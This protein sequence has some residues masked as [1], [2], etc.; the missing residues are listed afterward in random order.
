MVCLGMGLVLGLSMPCTVQAGKE[1][2]AKDL[3]I[4][5]WLSKGALFPSAKGR[6]AAGEIRGAHRGGARL[7]RTTAAY[8]T[9]QYYGIKRSFDDL[10][11]NGKFADPRSEIGRSPGSTGEEALP[12]VA[13]DWLDQAFPPLRPPMGVLSLGGT[14]NSTP[15][16][17]RK[18]TQAL[19]MP[20]ETLKSV[21]TF[22]TGPEGGFSHLEIQVSH[23]RHTF[24]LI[25]KSFFGRREVLYEC[26][27]GL[28]S[29]EFPTPRGTYFVTHIY[30]EDPWWIP[31]QNRWWAWGQAPSKRVYGGT[32]APLLKKRTLRSRKRHGADEDLVHSK[33]KLADHGYRFHGTNAPGSIG[34]NQSHGCVRMLSADARKVAGLI[35]GY[36][37]TSERQESENGTFVPLRAPVRLYLVR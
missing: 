35:K 4:E 13:G 2:D 23:S 5:N 34:R 37:G 30:D 22:P 19:L 29:P 21:G 18:R 24:K 36:V 14:W 26:K 27:I 3:W 15:L 6:S 31:P 9:D 33:V 32:M 11:P 28:G 16:L 10:G 12:R 25:G 1:L 17:D 20:Q 8:R 7:V